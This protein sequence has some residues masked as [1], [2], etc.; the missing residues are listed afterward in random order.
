[1][2]GVKPPPKSN[3]TAKEVQVANSKILAAQNLLRQIAVVKEKFTEAQKD[4][5]A[6][7]Y[8]IGANPT[9]EKGRQFDAAVN[10][11]RSSVTA[12]TRVPGVGSMS[13]FET[14]LDQAKMPSRADY[15]SV[16]S[17]QIQEMEDLAKGIIQG[18]STMLPGADA[19]NTPA[20]S[21]NAPPPASLPPVNDKGFKLMRDANGNQAYVGPNGEVEEVR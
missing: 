5:F 19:A 4:K 10:A 21:N 15:N 11:M 6:T 16:T 1:L 7:G 20:P 17:Q 3:L 18:Y 13:D 12:V 14:K 8:L 2:E 9:S